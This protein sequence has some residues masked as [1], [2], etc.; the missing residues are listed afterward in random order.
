MNSLL[1]R[2]IGFLLSS[3]GGIAN[4]TAEEPIATLVVLSNPYI[5]TLKKDIK[6]DIAYTL[7]VL[8]GV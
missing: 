8:G 3:L 4:G 6:D 5:T 7:E 2:G 1:L